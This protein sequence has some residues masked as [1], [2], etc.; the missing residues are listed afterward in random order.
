MNLRLRWVQLSL[1][2]MTLLPAVSQAQEA[3]KGEFA[4]QRFQP[5]PGPRNFFT[6]EGARTDGK[7]AWSAGLFV[8]YSDSPF[9]LRS[10][11]SQADCGAPNSTQPND[12][13]VIKTMVTGD[14]LASLTPIPKLQLGLRL[15]ITYVQGDGIDTATG[16]AA[17]DGLKGAGLGDP[18]LE[19]KLRALGNV[20]SPLVI[21]GSLFLAA[22][23]GSAIAKDKYIGDSGPVAGLRGILDGRAGPLDFGA[24]I[25]GLYRQAS[26]LGSVELGPEFRYGVAGGFRV[27]QVLRVVAEGFGST[28][29]SDKA[30]TSSLEVDGGVQISPLHSGIHINLGGGTGV[31]QGVGVPKYRGFLGLMYVSEVGDTDGDGLRDSDDKCPLDAED[32]DGYEDSDGCPELDNDGDGIKDT[33]DK[34]PLQPESMNGIDDTDGCPDSIPDSDKDGIPDADDKCPNDG[35]PN[36]VRAKGEFYGC[37]DNDKDGIPDSKDQCKDE[38]EDTDGFKDEDGCPDPDNARRERRGR[39]PLSSKRASPGQARAA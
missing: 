14:V 27:S 8:N 10:C 13:N 37:P 25:A 2:S 23:A 21:G 39:H 19:A 4:V 35:G 22:P 18:T 12:I 26:R 28:K 24:N 15:P 36:V 33:D 11:K 38:P 29:F 30:G 7:M 1:L 32:K 17:K 16:N 20:D 3:K 5:A 31:L 9:V 6:V 34:C